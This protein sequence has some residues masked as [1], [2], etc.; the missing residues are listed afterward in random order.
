MAV[1]C[2]SNI[3]LGP[4]MYIIE[5]KL[6]MLSPDGLGRMW[7]KDANGYARGDGVAA[8]T[9]KTLSAAL[10]DGDHI[11]CIIR[12]T[13]LNQDGATAGLTMPSATAQKALIRA[14]YAK[15]GLD[16]DSPAGRPQYF[17]AHGTGTP[18][19]DPVEA[20]AVSSAFF[21]GKHSGGKS[22]TSNDPLYVGSI[23]TVLGHTE[24]TAG[25]AAILK[26]SLALQNSCIPPNLLFN[27]ISPSVAPFYGDLQIV[28]DA[29]PWPAVLG[30]QPRRASVN[31]FGFGG[32]NAHAILES[33]DSLA[34]DFQGGGGADRTLFTPFV[35]SAASVDSLRANLTAYA[36]YLDAHAEVD[37]GDL[38][39]TLLQALEAD[40]AQL[41][42]EDRPTWSL[43]AEIFAGSSTPSRINE[44]AISQPL[45][46][47]LQIVMIELLRE[48]NIH[49]ESV[50]GHSSG[51][52]AAAYSA[53]FLT[54]RDA[55]YIAYYRGLHCRHAASPNGQIKG[56]MLAVGTSMEDAIQLCEDE[57][58]AGRINLAASNSSSSVTISGDEDAI[59][60]LES[61]LEDEKKF[62]RRLRVDMAYHSQH[63][64]PCSRPYIDS[65]RRAGVKA[66]S[67]PSSSTCTCA[68]HVLRWK[69]ILKPSKIPWLEGHKVQGQIVFPASAYLSTAVEAAS[70]LAD[71]KTIKL[72]ELSNFTIHQGLG[73]ES[74]DA[75]IEVQIELTRISQLKSDHL[76]AYFTYSAATG[77]AEDSE[78]TLIA[79]GELTIRLGEASL[80]LLPARRPTAPHLLTVDPVRLYNFMESLEYNFS[81]PFL[82]LIE[83]RRKLGIASCV[84][85]KAKASSQPDADLLLI[86]PVELDAAIQSVSLA[87][88]Y[89]GDEQLRL[90]H[91]PTTI[92]KI[93][94]NPAVLALQHTQGT[95]DDDNT[96]GIDSTCNRDR[97]AQPG[98]GFS[99]NFN[100][101]AN[102]CPNAAIQ[103]DQVKFQPVRSS[104]SDDRNVF[105]KM[106]YVPCE[107]DGT[108][109]AADIPITKSDTDLLWAFSRIV[110]YYLREFDRVPEDHPIRSDGTLKH[111]LR[112]ARHMTTLLKTGGHRY[113]KVDWLNDKLEDVMAEVESKGL[114]ENPVVKIM[115]LVG[116][117]MPKVFRGETTM[118][119]HF[120]TSGLLDEYYAKGFGTAQS[121]MWLSNIVKQITDRRPHLNLLEIGAGT[122]G[123]TKQILRT[124]DRSFDSYTFTDIS[125]SFFE[126]AAE[127]LAQWR[128]RMVFKV[129]DAEQNPVDQGFVEGQ[130]D[131][132]IAFLV[133]HATAKLDDTMR[134]LRKLLKPGGFLLI[135]EGNSEAGINIRSK[136]WD[137][138]LKR[139]GFSGIDTISPQQLLDTF[140]TILFVS[141]A[142]DERIESI[143][144]PLK[145]SPISSFA[146]NQL[147]IV[148]GKTPEVA[149]V[150]EQIGNIL[151]P[152]FS[153]THIYATLEELEHVVLNDRL[154]VISLTELEQPVF[155]NITPERWSGF[156]KLFV[157]E[158][159]VLWLTSGRLEDEP[160][161]NMTVGFGRSAV[162]EEEDL[163][164]QLLDIPNRKHV[165]ARTI[166]ETF[167]RL[168]ARHSSDKDILYTMEPEVITDIEGRQLVP[169]LCPIQGANDRLNCVQ[170]PIVH[171]VDAKTTEFELQWDHGSYSIRQLSRFE[172]S[173]FDERYV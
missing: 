6:K 52:I 47:A 84:A 82:S 125:S 137:A 132:V 108:L 121:T 146:E 7:D 35:F 15:A 106:Q 1:A 53:G 126:N 153:Q 4:E 111:Y 26:A 72:I 103:V 93:R 141:Q 114:A 59:E 147:A 159:I 116:N 45:C 25:V 17:E 129:C 172:A 139:T 122:G 164:L 148:G 157:G 110:C 79:D 158:K 22:A 77:G 145:T 120:R 143:R 81:G 75:G 20:E 71:G 78:L 138:I 107:P 2:G 124:I 170:R 34:N 58:F 130:Y 27:N 134:N 140:G 105:Y 163:V 156:R 55:I 119:E 63:M 85:R 29:R 173:I 99:G 16:I 115:L 166:A 123:A 9:L 91:M 68:A 57:E 61:V 10:E 30:G 118:L 23:K 62:H 152:S 149:A 33:Y 136:K 112:Y 128:D 169:R 14:T 168:A 161:A 11:E 87:Y 60:E 38:A 36:A 19:G 100:I 80:S 109:A 162:H 13:G 155:K 64:D 133:V 44:A 37:F 18:A 144:A 92:A 70:S 76:T 49:L 32:T 48:A 171:E 95:V 40:L 142:T 90:L 102:G 89:P 39:Y 86:H 98:S 50:V 165:D 160:Y 151:G 28:K 21:D 65:L 154:S 104:A 56:A 8:I 69:N 5:S 67:P 66:R 54:A 43:E 31:S 150:A 3:I 117:T 24:G 46:T 83:L 127:N 12:E 42:A 96:V 51:E 167:A 97:R 131:V 41:P 135:G 74:R 73:F 94:V 101:Y 88:S 113:G